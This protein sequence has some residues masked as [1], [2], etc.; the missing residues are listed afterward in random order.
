MGCGSCYIGW[1]RNS[2]TVKKFLPLSKVSGVYSPRMEHT[3]AGF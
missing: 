2:I 1:L 3:L